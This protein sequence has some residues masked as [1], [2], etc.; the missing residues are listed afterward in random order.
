MRSNTKHQKTTGKFNFWPDKN[1]DLQ[2]WFLLNQL[3]TMFHSKKVNILLGIWSFE[4][5]WKMAGTS[6]FVAHPHPECC[7]GFVFKNSELLLNKN[8][9]IIGMPCFKC[10]SAKQEIY[11]HPSISWLQKLFLVIKC[12]P[13]IFFYFYFFLFF[14]NLLHIQ[15]LFGFLRLGVWSKFLQPSNGVWLVLQCKFLSARHHVLQ[16]NLETNSFWVITNIT[17]TS[18]RLNQNMLSL[19]LK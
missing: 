12:I 1:R 6:H 13:N 2:D 19:A 3:S 9:K 16:A 10:C 17:L 8:G 18:N 14:K 5:N 7:C 4:L 11:Q 15:K